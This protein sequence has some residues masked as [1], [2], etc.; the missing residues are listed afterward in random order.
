M[1]GYIYILSNPSMPTLVKIGKTTTSPAQRMQELHSTG[2]PTPFELEFAAEVSDCDACE[3]MAHHL[4]EEHRVSVNREFFEVSVQSAIMEILANL[5]DYKLVAC[6]ES[7][8]IKEIEDKLTRKREEKQRIIREQEAERER[9][10][11]QRIATLQQ[12]LANA[13]IRLRNIGSRPAEPVHGWPLIFLF[14]C[15]LPM[16]LGWIAL[17]GFLGPKYE[18]G[19]VCLALLAAAFIAYK[20]WRA[21]DDAYT[22]ANEPFYLIDQEIKNLEKAIA[23]EA[24]TSSPAPPPIDKPPRLSAPES[25]EQRTDKIILPCPECKK[26]IRLPINKNL[27]VTCSHCASV[28]MLT[29]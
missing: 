10:R 18:S 7:H 6:K 22:K 2:V 25:Q 4:L 29:T 23:K 26:R 28:F 24:G 3:R 8:G 13:K 9:E 16:P 5:D 20:D 14:V 1:K 19:Y 27:E 11:N 17:Q 21:K 15:G 12:Q